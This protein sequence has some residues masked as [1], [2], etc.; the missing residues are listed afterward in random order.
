M[1][2][3][4]ILENG[5][6]PSFYRAPTD[7]DIGAGLNKSLREWRKA[8]DNN[9]VEDVKT[10]QLNAGSYKVSFTKNVLNGKAKTQQSFTIF[11]DGTIKVENNFT[12]DKGDFK[13][14]MRIGNNLQVN[15]EF[16]RIQWYG[17]GP[18]ENYWDRKYAGEVACTHVHA[19]TKRAVFSVR[20]PAGKR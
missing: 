12:V 3:M 1:S 5:P 2:G 10:E 20:A 15:K 8:Y 7:N 19:K 6:A 13:S 18:W 11:G 14:L 4:Q 9:I 16:T 17:R